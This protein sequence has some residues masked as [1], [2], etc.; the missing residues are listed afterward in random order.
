MHAQGVDA[1]LLSL[2]AD[3][4]YLTGYEAMPLERL[5]MLVILPDQQA[6]LVVPRLEAPRVVPH[7]DVFEVVTWDETDDPIAIV[8]RLVG[9]VAVAA[10]GDQTWARFL[11]ELTGR[12]PTT[13]FVS[14][15]GVCG[16]VRELKD[17]A[18]I[19]ALGIAAAAVD[20]IAADLQG[21]AVPMVGLTEREVAVDI[22]SRMRDEGHHR[23]A[24]VTVAAGPNSASPH[25]EAGD[26]VIEVGQ[27][28][29]FDFGGA[30][31]SRDGVGYCSDITRCVWLGEPPQEFV[32]LY[33]ALQHAQQVAVASAAVGTT[34]GEVDAVARRFIDEAGFGE[35]FVHRTGHGI[36]IETH[37]EPYIVE[38]NDHTLQPGHVF[39]IEPGI[40]VPGR[41]GARIE[42]IVVAMPD[43]PQPLNRADHGLAVLDV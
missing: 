29:L 38:G 25:H 35:Y 5:T 40:Y 6:A 16:P 32:D 30:V 15:S 14:A 42:D 41:W 12:L 11:I 22:A 2:G 24:F 26:T 37:E 20:R 7:P 1:L 23:V 36:G 13:T 4:P 33:G 27:G 10:I 3:L 31:L 9:D 19:E 21:G 34:C 39:S 43:G 8:A 28:V 17:E 18:E